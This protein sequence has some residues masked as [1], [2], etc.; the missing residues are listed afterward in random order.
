MEFM[1][2]LALN[3]TVQSQGALVADSVVQSIVTNSWDSYA[4]LL[5]A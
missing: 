2:A 3:A 4:N 5:V 1:S